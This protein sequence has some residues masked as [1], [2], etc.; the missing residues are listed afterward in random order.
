MAKM[1]VGRNDPCPCGSGK[2]YKKCCLAREATGPLNDPAADVSAGLRQ[3]LEGREF[4][5]LEEARAFAEGFMR[6]RNRAPSDDFHGLSPEQMHSILYRPFDSPQL[7]R[8]PEQLDTTPGAPILTLFKLLADAIGEQGLKPTAKGNLPR[9]FCREAALTFMGEKE[10]AQYTRYGNI[11]KEED[12]FDLHV[13]RL[14]AEMAGLVRKYKGRFILSRDCR[15]LLS[16]A[17][18]P[19]V[20]PRLLRAY[21]KKFNWGYRDG[22]PEIHL[23]QQSFLFFLYLLS[24]YGGEWR[25]SVFYEDCF[26]QAFPMVLAELESHPVFTPEQEVRSCY[27]LRTLVHFAGFLGLAAVE[28]GETENPYIYNYRVRKLPLLDQAVIFHLGRG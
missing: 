17:G 7:V 19:A 6:Q 24:R 25:S 11:N 9:Q 22:Y 18:F 8:F 3:V 12:F 23:I 2:K 13:T 4:G 1:D 28:E 15:R 14:V 21:N 20:Y 16:E 26:L 5:S 27:T 10:H